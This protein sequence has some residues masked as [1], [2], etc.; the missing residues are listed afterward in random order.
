MTADLTVGEQIVLLALDEESGELREAPLRVSLACSAAA[1]LDEQRPPTREQLLA[2]REA[3]LDAAYQGLLEKRIVREQGRRVLGAFGSAK[4]PVI[5][6]PQL[7]ALRARLTAVRE[8]DTV[9]LAVLHHAGLWA[10]LPQS[11][12]LTES[13]DRSAEL[14]DTIRTTIAALTAVIAST[15]L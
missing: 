4:H 6:P 15:A 7:T 12:A 9:L 11:P 10:V 3:A 13:Q 2:T 8:E 14:G 1:A 5:D